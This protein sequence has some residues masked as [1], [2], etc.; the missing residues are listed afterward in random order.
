MRRAGYVERRTSGSGSGQG[1]LTRGDTG[2]AS[3][4]DFHHNFLT[5]AS[6]LD[7]MLAEARKY[8]LSMVLAHQ[9]L[10][11]FPRDLHAAVS[12]NARN[13]IY[14]TC[15][16]EDAHTLARHTLP[17]LD[18]HDLT[19]LD[20]YTAIA[21]LVIDGQQTHA[22]TLRTRPPRPTLGYATTIRQTAADR[23]PV[24]QKSAL[25]DL[26]R[27]LATPNRPH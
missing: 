6:S 18:E 9:D 5:L 3:L 17:H 22:F 26:A 14:F 2:R 13:K 27:R 11:Q 4:A 8:R 24:P 21:R 25:D 23:T 7:T 16:P 12:T 1:K 19:H 15:S 10:A 20:A